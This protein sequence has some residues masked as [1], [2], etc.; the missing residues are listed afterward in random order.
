VG[1]QLSRDVAIDQHL[2]RR[3]KGADATEPPHGGCAYGIP[4]ASSASD[5][6]SWNTTGITIGFDG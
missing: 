1:W 3:P 6:M 2:S 5:M 4:D